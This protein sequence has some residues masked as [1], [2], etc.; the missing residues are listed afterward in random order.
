[1]TASLVAAQ[2]H[3]HHRHQHAKRDAVVTMT[4]C[5]VL[6]ESTVLSPSEC[7]AGLNAQKYSFVGSETT[8]STTS[9]T[10]IPSVAAAFFEST[11]TA[12]SVTVPTSSSTAAAAPSDAPKAKAASYNTGATGADAPFPDGQLDCSSVPT[13]YGALAIDSL[14]I[15]GWIGLQQIDSNNAVTST[16]TSNSQSR[17][18]EG[19][20]CSYACAP[21][22]QKSQWPINQPSTLQSVGGLLCKGG[23]LHLT[24]PNFKTIC[25]KG[26][27]VS[28]VKNKLGSNVAVCRTDYPGTESE[29]VPMDVPGGSSME[30]TCPDAKSYFVWNNSPTSAQYYVNPAGTMAK[31]GCQWAAPGS[32][33]GNDAPVNLGIN[34]DQY[35]QSW[36]A[37]LPNHPTNYHSNL[38]FSIELEGDF[39]GDKCSYK[40]GQYCMNGNCNSVGVTVSFLY[41]SQS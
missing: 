11:T 1:M 4:A 26:T 39:G 23:K 20:M 3:H 29:T 19:W 40:N 10:S 24:N 21:G 7:T 35:G 13:Q 2:P 14:G 33:I 25:I 27:G 12:A 9:S 37:I 36:F 41:F 5:T 32:G 8:A 28:Q 18:A 34:T 6:G 38:D 15:N 17:C 16:G 30:L 31:D 22:Y